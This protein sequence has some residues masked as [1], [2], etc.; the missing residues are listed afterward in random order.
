MDIKVKKLI[1]EEIEFTK[2]SRG[3]KKTMNNVYF[4]CNS[5]VNKKKTKTLI[6]ARKSVRNIFYRNI[7]LCFLIFV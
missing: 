1:F 4:I 2:I 7:F 6:V 5:P 3:Y